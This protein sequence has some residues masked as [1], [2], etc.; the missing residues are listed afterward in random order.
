MRPGRAILFGVLGAAAISLL[1]AVLRAA[2]LPL[3]IEIILGTL[4]GLP[5]G[6]TAFGLG[7]LI[8]LTMGGLFGL[9]YGYLFENVWDHGGASTGM[10]TAV[11]HASLIGILIG[12]T[13]QFH[14]LIPERMPDPGPY[15]AN[16]GV[17]GVLTFFGAHLVY[18]AIVGAGYGHVQAEHQWAPSGRL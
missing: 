2:G 12:L 8:H 18:G 7:L 5:A 6:G 3:S 9:L 14:P 15:F 11:V 10:L 16:L 13:P 17:A 1:T 4:T